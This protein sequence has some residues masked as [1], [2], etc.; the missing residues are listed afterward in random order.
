MARIKVDIWTGPLHQQLL[1]ENL[2]DSW[3][4]AGPAIREALAQGQLAN[5]LMDHP[6][7]EEEER[8]VEAGPAPDLWNMAL[9]FAGEPACAVQLLAEAIA[10]GCDA[11]REDCDP[12]LIER[13]PGRPN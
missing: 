1:S 13:Q 7:T 11:L 12:I 10:Q 8:I 9:E 6:L 5:V 4:T 3:D 2:H